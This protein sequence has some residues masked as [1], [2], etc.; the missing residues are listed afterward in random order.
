MN[1]NTLHPLVIDRHCGELSP[2]AVELLNHYLDQHED[3]RVE[4][5]RWEQALAVTGRTVMQHPELVA[6]VPVILPVKAKPPFAMRTW[7]QRAAAAALLAAT[8]AGGFIAGRSSF[9]SASAVKPPASPSAPVSP[10]SHSPWARYRMAFDRTTSAMQI[11][12]VDSRNT[13]EIP[14]Q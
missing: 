7:L 2:E 11:V 5:E 8:A 12:R 10:S 9:E 6:R 4:A 3:A 13:S 14:V 1:S